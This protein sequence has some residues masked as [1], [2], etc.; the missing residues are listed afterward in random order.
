MK[1]I[2]LIIGLTL[3]FLT[4]C[5]DFLEEENLSNVTSEEFYVTVKGYESLINANYAAFREIY[6]QD[7][8]LFMAGTDLYSEGKTPEPDGLSK[9]IELNPSSDGVDFL[10]NVCF[11]AIQKANTAIFYSEITEQTPNISQWV[12]EVKFLRADAYFL[13]VQTYGGVSLITELIDEAVMEFERN[14]AEE[15][16]DFIVSE[17]EG[18]LDLVYDGDFEG[19]VNKRTVQHLLAKVHLTRAYKAFAKNDDYSKAGSYADDVINGQSLN[20]SFEEL[21]TPGNELNE[22]VIFS[23]QYSAGSISINPTSA[24]H[25]QQNWHGSYLGGSE[26]AGDAP[27]KSYNLCL[28]QFALDLFTEDDERWAATFMTEIYERYYDY[29]D[30]DDKSSLTVT[31]FYEPQW[32]T[33]ADSIDY[34]TINPSLAIYH[35]YGTFGPDGWTS[36]LYGVITV[37]KFDDPTSAYSLGGVSTRDFIVSRLG[38]T[39]LIAAEA[40]LGAG[41]NETGLARLNEVRRRAGVANA[42]LAEFDIDFILDESARETIGE[43]HRWFD[44]KRTGKLVERASAHNP[45]IEEINFVGNGGELKILRPIPQKALD[46]NQNKDFSQNPAYI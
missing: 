19:R 13:L 35:S 5:N 32:F 21:W 42:T 40:Y 1:N 11:A 17:L 31:H 26:V 28:N 2:L 30:V 25:Q 29:Y 18:V 46:L 37:K 24:G 3:I 8:W 6:G 15:I 27:Y 23:I 44:L 9:Y 41:E 22:E 7:P 4:G 36:A 14:S 10:Y 45:L 34:V 16:Y 38:E 39:Y 12:A 43:Y 20:L 33:Q